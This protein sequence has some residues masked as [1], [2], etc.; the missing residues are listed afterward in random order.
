MPISNNYRFYYVYAYLI[1]IF[2]GGPC[3]IVVLRGPMSEKG[4]N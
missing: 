1:F 4:P 3:D 2:G